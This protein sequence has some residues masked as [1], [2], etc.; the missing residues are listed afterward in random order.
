MIDL[1]SRELERDLGVAMSMNRLPVVGETVTL[2]T[3]METTTE[4]ELSAGATGTVVSVDSQDVRVEFTCSGGRPNSP[5][6]MEFEDSVYI[7][8]DELHEF[9][10][11]FEWDEDRED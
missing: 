7:A 9:L 10:E 6:G 1:S 5:Y 2:T 11:G 3:H 8:T 4:F